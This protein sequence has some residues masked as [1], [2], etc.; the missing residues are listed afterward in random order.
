MKDHD[1]ILDFEHAFK[2]K[3]RM[4]KQLAKKKSSKAEKDVAYSLHALEQIEERK[5]G[6]NRVEKCLQKGRRVEKHGAVH[7]ILENLHVVLNITEN[8]VL[9]AYNSSD[10]RED[11][12]A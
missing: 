12:A 11:L 6:K 1:N 4:N 3:N 8:I 5:L 9:T 2:K 7:Y 10:M